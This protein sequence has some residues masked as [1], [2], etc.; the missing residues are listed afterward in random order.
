MC[1]FG[2]KKC[3]SKF[4]I[5]LARFSTQTPSRGRGF[6]ASEVHPGLGSGVSSPKVHGDRRGGS[7]KKMGAFKKE[8]VIHPLSTFELLSPSLFSLQPM[9]H[10]VL[11]MATCSQSVSQMGPPTL[12]PGSSCSSQEPYLHRQPPHADRQAQI[13]GQPWFFPR[14]LRESCPLLPP[15]CPARPSLP[16]S[17]LGRRVPLW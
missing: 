14:S 4:D 7:L 8:G 6:Q 16:C 17:P 11:G 12:W 13:L 3:A 2:N 5:L 10:C 1:S 9:S 15:P